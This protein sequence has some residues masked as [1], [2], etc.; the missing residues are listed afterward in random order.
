MVSV[1]EF[2]EQDLTGARFERVSLRGAT[3]SQVR[4]NDARVNSVDIAPLIDAVLNRR[5]VARA[6]PGWPR[7]AN[8]PVKEC[9]HIVLNKE[10]EHRLFAERDLT[11]LEKED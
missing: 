9:L 6:E 10:W 7:V 3:F 5:E 2:G 11:T 1:T 8:F 4:L